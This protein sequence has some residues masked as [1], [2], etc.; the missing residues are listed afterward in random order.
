MKKI[1]FA[2]IICLIPFFCDAQ[3][4][5]VTKKKS[6]GGTSEY[7][8]CEELSSD[9][10]TT[11]SS[12]GTVI[13]NVCQ[14]DATGGT[15]T[16]L[17]VRM[18]SSFVDSGSDYVKMVCANTSGGD[19]SSQSVIAQVE[20]ALTPNTDGNYCF[21][22][23]GTPSLSGTTYYYIGAMMS[24]P[25]DDRLSYSDS[26]SGWATFR[27]TGLTYSTSYANPLDASYEYI[28]TRH[29]SVWAIYEH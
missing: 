14:T 27:K 21:D 9:L 18:A 13:G 3:Q 16:K 6:G 23:S 26:A 7:V 2:I 10:A 1:I 15:L 28:A 11:Y 17:C 4:I 25:G 8:L 12:E 24:D 19:P 20:G 29:V 22:V 5:I